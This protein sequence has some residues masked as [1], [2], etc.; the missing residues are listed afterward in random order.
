MNPYR[1]LYAVSPT[2]EPYVI[3]LDPCDAFIRLAGGTLDGI[4]ANQAGRYV[5]VF[6]ASTTDSATLLHESAYTRATHRLLL[7]PAR[8]LVLSPNAGVI[9]RR[10]DSA[11]RWRMVCV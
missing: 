4:E 6:N 1:E 2:R 3:A 8:D 11:A 10:D 5:F 9:L 7:L